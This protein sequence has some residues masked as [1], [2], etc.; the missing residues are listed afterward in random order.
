MPEEL[1]HDI[2]HERI[3][4]C[5][6][7]VI[8]LDGYPRYPGQVDSVYDLAAKS[9][10]DLAGMIFTKTDD[11]TALARLTKRNRTNPARHRQQP[12][13]A[14]ARMAEFDDSMH[15]LREA[16]WQRQLLPFDIDTTGSKEDTIDR[17]LAFA[18]LALCLPETS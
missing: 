8:F 4:A 18:A 6:A 12:E 10:R 5:D 3:E 17:G 2:V 16:L 13:S 9:E 11:I 7:S 15:N 14:L 1:I